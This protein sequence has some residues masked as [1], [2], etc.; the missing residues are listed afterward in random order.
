MDRV[1]FV[2]TVIRWNGLTRLLCGYVD[3]AVRA[4]RRCEA[5]RRGVRRPTHAEYE[6]GR[7]RNSGNRIQRIILDLTTPLQ[8]LIRTGEAPKPRWRAK[9]ARRRKSR[10]SLL[11]IA[12]PLAIRLQLDVHQLRLLPSPALATALPRYSQDAARS[13]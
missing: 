10:L 9:S 8:P 2:C 5:V 11:P 13:S 4:V 7:S 12:R 1:A 6:A 3:T